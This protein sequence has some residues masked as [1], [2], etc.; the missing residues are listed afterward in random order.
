MADPGRPFRQ[1]LDALSVRVV[2]AEPVEKDGVTLV[3]AAAVWGGGGA[4]GGTSDE[5]NG[6]GGGLGLVARPVG[7]YVIKDGEVRWVPAIDPWL[8]FMAGC[9]ALVVIGRILR[10]R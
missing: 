4:G 1:L 6:E 7:A 5:G 2:Y 3:P 10:R 8:V 9:L